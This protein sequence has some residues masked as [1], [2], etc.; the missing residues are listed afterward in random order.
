VGEQA[1]IGQIAAL[2]RYP[3]K[4]MGGESLVSAL[5]TD[6]GLIG[7]R[8]FALSDPAT[9]DF[10]TAREVPALFQY[11]AHYGA[12]PAPASYEPVRIGFPDGSERSSADPDLEA[13]LAA[14]LGCPVRLIHQP[15]E[16]F[17]S[18]PLHLITTAAL[19]TLEQRWGRILDPR[20]FRA[21][22]L[23]RTVDNREPFPE[24]RWLGATLVVGD[25][26][27]LHI[28]KPCTRC[29]MITQ[30]PDTCVRD[31]QLLTAVG[32]LHAARFGVYAHVV[33]GGAVRVGDAIRLL[34]D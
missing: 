7:D 6:Q 26:I 3:V 17:D 2:W 21:N 30:D 9:D 28:V 13:V 19:H 32:A 25:Q 23:V 15:G 1:I 4:S 29:V 27:R 5:I 12:V 10:L 14:D 24:D 33:H 16:L 34:T 20:R 31:P 11:H 18:R 8:A 22:I